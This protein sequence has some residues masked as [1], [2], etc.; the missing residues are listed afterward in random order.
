MDHSS[1]HSRRRCVCAPA[2]NTKPPKGVVTERGVKEERTK[3]FFARFH[4]L[5]L[6]RLNIF[7]SM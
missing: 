1:M 2:G 6:Q 7:I 5:Y 3:G 4:C